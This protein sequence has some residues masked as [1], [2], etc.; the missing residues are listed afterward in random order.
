MCIYVEDT[1]PQ[2]KPTRIKETE[3]RKNEPEKWIIIPIYTR[4]EE[5]IFFYVENEFTSESWV[6]YA[7]SRTALSGTANGIRVRAYSKCPKE[8]T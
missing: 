5:T 4:K 1:T 2:R 8:F 7:R 3:R 6:R